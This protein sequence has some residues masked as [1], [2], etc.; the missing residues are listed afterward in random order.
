MT[1]IRCSQKEQQALAIAMKKR[2]V[3]KA[4]PDIIMM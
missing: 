3:E 2:D 4:P 1:R